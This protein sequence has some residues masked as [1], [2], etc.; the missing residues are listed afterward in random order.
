[1][2]GSDDSWPYLDPFLSGNTNLDFFGLG[3]EFP[4]LS[5]SVV[6][7]ADD[8]AVVSFAVRGLRHNRRLQTINF[9]IR[10]FHPGREKRRSVKYLGPIRVTVAT[11]EQI[12]AMLQQFNTTL[13]QI[14]GL[15][16]ESR[17][18]EERINCLLELNR[19]GKDFAENGDRVPIG[20]WGDVLSRI[21]NTECNSFVTEKVQQACGS[22][23]SPSSGLHDPGMKS[24]RDEL[25]RTKDRLAEAEDESALLRSENASLREQLESL[26]EMSARHG[27]ELEQALGAS[28]GKRRR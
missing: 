7:F 17:E 8:Q 26:R 11:S 4:V 22:Y 28:R 27:R 20:L 23:E 10:Q 16:Y 25:A 9:C 12:V 5:D 24:L 2:N 18:H 13:Q 1:V 3:I 15:E 6:S 21:S 19:H 14:E